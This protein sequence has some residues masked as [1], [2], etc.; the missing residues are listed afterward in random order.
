MTD[1]GLLFPETFLP[2]ID[3]KYETSDQADTDSDLEY[4]GKQRPIL[5]AVAL[6]FL[7]MTRGVGYCVHAFS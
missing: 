4:I 6:E 3:P 1:A 2:G 7:R 5:R